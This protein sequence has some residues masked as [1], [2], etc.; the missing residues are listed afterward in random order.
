ML[1]EFFAIHACSGCPKRNSN[2]VR[3]RQPHIESAEKNFHRTRGTRLTRRES[4]PHS[5]KQSRW[6]C[7]L[8]GAKS[9]KGVA[10]NPKAP[11]TF[12]L[13]I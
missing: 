9:G 4:K 2:P 1:A 13:Q 12:S 8:A 3:R 5:Q 7:G 10:K 6:Q 11:S